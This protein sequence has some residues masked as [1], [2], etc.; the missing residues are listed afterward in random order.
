MQRPVDIESPFFTLNLDLD[1]VGREGSSVTTI[2][3][4]LL[5][6]YLF[7]GFLAI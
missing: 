5:P 6:P 4:F 2:L 1:G 7:F 3:Y